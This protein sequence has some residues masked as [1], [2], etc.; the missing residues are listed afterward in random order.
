MLP[1]SD[2]ECFINIDKNVRLNEFI[3]ELP[4][5]LLLVKTSW[6]Y[7]M[8]YLQVSQVFTSGMNDS[9]YFTKQDSYLQKNQ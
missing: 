3:N 5:K 4:L 6:N 9:F 8:S 2:M 7:P 1:G